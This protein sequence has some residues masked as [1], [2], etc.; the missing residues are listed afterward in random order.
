ML[1]EI[2]AGQGADVPTQGSVP[3]LFRSI[4]GRHLKRFE[5]GMGGKIILFLLLDNFLARL[6]TAILFQD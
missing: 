1:L 5:I 2:F 3:G 4:T 6:H